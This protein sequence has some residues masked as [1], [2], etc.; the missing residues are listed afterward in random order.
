M[1]AAHV[2]FGARLDERKITR[3]QTDLRLGAENLA[4]EKREHALEIAHL[5]AAIDPKAFDLM[6]HRR[7]SRIAVAAINRARAKNRESATSATRIA[8]I[9]TDEVCV[10]ST[11]PGPMKKCPAY[12]AQD[13]L[14]E[15]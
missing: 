8:R 11:T 10:R 5:H 3:T 1:K 6:E 13:D 9:C 14:R 2:D 15:Y 12:R 4:R 7:V